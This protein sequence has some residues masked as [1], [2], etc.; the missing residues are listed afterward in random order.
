MAI[1]P[2]DKAAAIVAAAIIYNR[3]IALLE[4]GDSARASDLARD[5]AAEAAVIVYAVE[6]H[7][8]PKQRR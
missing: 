2:S 4:P 8:A 1:H 3:K 7:M 5:A 6:K